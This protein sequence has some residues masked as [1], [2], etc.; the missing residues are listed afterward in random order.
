MSDTHTELSSLATLM[1]QHGH[2][3][4]EQVSADS[5]SAMLTVVRRM[6]RQAEDAIELRD[7]MIRLARQLGATLTDVAEAAGVAPQ[8][9]ANICKRG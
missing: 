2:E 9:V 3:F 1:R 5:A 8:T 6:A 7:G 4:V